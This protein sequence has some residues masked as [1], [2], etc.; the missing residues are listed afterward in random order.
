M[1]KMSARG[2]SIIFRGK[3]KKKKYLVFGPIFRTPS[4]GGTCDGV[5]GASTSPSDLCPLLRSRNTGE[6][7]RGDSP[8]SSMYSMLENPVL[9]SLRIENA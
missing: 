6:R 7:F 9:R 2:G 8:S 1:Q 5:G 4:E 3:G